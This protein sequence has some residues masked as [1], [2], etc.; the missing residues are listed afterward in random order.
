MTSPNQFVRRVCHFW[1]NGRA[2][3]S[4]GQLQPGYDDDARDDSDGDGDKG[5]DDDASLTW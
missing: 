4:S 1:C 3:G 2:G 5:Y